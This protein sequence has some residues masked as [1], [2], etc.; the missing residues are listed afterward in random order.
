[1]CGVFLPGAQRVNPRGHLEIGG[2]DT[3]ELAA[4]FGTPLYVFDEA[5][6]RHQCREYRRAFE[7]RY[8]SVRIEYATK[9]FL[10]IAMAQLVHQEGLHLDVASAG[11]LYTALQA[12]VPG[13]ELVFHGNNKSV[14]ELRLALE[15]GVGRIVVDNFHELDLL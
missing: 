11:E 8:P 12:G 2:C 6:I 13:S 7:T 1:M 9:A 14:D 5:H 4:E 10:C 3:V 15:A